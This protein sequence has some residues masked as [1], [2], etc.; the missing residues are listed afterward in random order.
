MV[1][2]E[3]R[4]KKENDLIS[5]SCQ[6]WGELQHCYSSW[7]WLEKEAFWKV[8]DLGK[9]ITLG[10]S[11]LLS[12]FLLETTGQPWAR[13][14]WHGLIQV[15]NKE[16]MDINFSHRSFSLKHRPGTD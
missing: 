6:K 2:E 3:G 5:H 11:I 1:S 7:K 16:Q 4:G 10:M 8:F 14:H 15:I 12:K 9:K 13:L